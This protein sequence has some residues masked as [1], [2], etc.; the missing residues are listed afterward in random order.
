MVARRFPRSSPF[1][2]ASQAIIFLS[3]L[4]LTASMALA[5]VGNGTPKGVERTSERPVARLISSSSTEVP[6]R[7]RERLIARASMPSTA[8]TRS[9]NSAAAVVAATGEER[10]AFDLI[11]AERQR[12]GLRSLTW[13]GS[14][15]RLARYH[16]ENMARGQ[17]LSH[18][19]R[20]G[21]DL[22]GRAEVLGL[23]GWRALG[24]NIAY[25]QGYSDPTAFAVERWMIS[26]KHREN[27][28]NGEYTHA[29]VGV[30]R[31]SD[32]TY[33]FTQV[34]MMR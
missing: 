16:S 5:N 22:K 14:L 32:G 28:L 23:H 9:Y 6:A 34:F 10:R 15:T 25:N 1:K 20:D 11:N 21:L 4:G 30:A 2:R 13:D 18:V 31:A 19:D 17:F 12:R 8:S 27:I 29:A 3:S 26:E 7:V 24:E 33:Y